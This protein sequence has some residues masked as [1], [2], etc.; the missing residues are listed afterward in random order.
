MQKAGAVADRPV[1]R[2]D[3]TELLFSR[4]Y[5]DIVEERFKASR[6]S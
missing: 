3:V 5:T 4:L 1:P 2:A 6:I